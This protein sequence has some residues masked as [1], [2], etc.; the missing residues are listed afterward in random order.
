MKNRCKK[1]KY[2]NI[3]K[4]IEAIFFI[5]FFF[6][7]YIKMVSSKEC[8]LL[9]Q[10]STIFVHLYF[11]I[12]SPYILPWTSSLFHCI[13]QHRII[14]GKIIQDVF[15]LN[16]EPDGMIYIYIR[17]GSLRHFVFSHMTRIRGADQDQICIGSAFLVFNKWYLHLRYFYKLTLIKS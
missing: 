9:W 17:F 7:N 16:E 12:R 14:F 1:F 3:N 15:W 4:A 11:Y 5:C 6:Y 10:T 13:F 8:S 2:K